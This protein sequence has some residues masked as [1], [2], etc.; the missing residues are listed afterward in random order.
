M[1]YR[2]PNLTRPLSTRTDES[3]DAKLRSQRGTSG[4]LR[5]QRT[6]WD[7]FDGGAERPSWAPPPRGPTYDWTSGF[8]KCQPD[9]SSYYY[10]RKFEGDHRPSTPDPRPSWDSN[11]PRPGPELPND[12]PSWDNTQENRQS[13]TPPSPDWDNIWVRDQQEKA[14]RLKK[15]REA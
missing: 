7:A 2:F 6:Q 9:C 12:Y 10:W 14:E 13:Y 8:P 4:S 5:K 1:L 3:S 15:E 11:G